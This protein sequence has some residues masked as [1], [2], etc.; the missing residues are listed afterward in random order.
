MV[1][2]QVQV[3]NLLLKLVIDTEVF[4]EVFVRHLL[5]I[6]DMKSLEELVVILPH[7]QV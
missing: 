4:L 3:G 6:L 5:L 2:Q 1:L 7:Q